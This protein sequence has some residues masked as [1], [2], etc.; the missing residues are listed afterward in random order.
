[1][2]ASPLGRTRAVA[3]YRMSIDRQETSITTNRDAVAKLTERAASIFRRS[4][5]TSRDAANQ[6]GKAQPRSGSQ[7]RKRSAIASKRRRQTGPN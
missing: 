7:L 1:M 3:C 5:I 2:S 4:A 6:T